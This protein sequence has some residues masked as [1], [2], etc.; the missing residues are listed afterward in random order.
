MFRTIADRLKRPAICAHFG[1]LPDMPI[2]QKLSILRYQ[3]LEFWSLE[4]ASEACEAIAGFYCS[5]PFRYFLRYPELDED[6][7]DK[8]SGEEWKFL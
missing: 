5:V 1:L 8:L 2:R 3:L 4:E 7:E 6:G